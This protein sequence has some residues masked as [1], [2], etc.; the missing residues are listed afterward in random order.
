MTDV[1]LL[2]NHKNTTGS[3]L[4]HSCGV[5]ADDAGDQP[6][7]PPCRACSLG[8]PLRDIDSAGIDSS[9]LSEVGVAVQVW[10][11]WKTSYRLRQPE[12]EKVEVASA[13]I[14]AKQKLSVDA[15]LSAVANR[16][17]SADDRRKASDSIAQIRR[18]RATA[19]KLAGIDPW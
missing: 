12:A 19:Q 16:T 9:S 15:P 4:E 5:V 2:K 7:P 10:R 3:K 18:N 8:M 13:R 17:K 6:P 1:I 11:G 14:A